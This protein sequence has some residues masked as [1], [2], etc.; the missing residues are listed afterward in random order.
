MPWRKLCRDLPIFDRASEVGQRRKA[1]LPCIAAE[2]IIYRHGILEA[3][4]VEEAC[5]WL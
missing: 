5:K 3:H 2:Q 1:M 4:S